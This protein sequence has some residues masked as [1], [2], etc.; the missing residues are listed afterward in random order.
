M[1]SEPL[2]AADRL[3]FHRILRA[4]SPLPDAALAIVDPAARLRRLARGEAFLA[5]GDVATECGVVLAGVMREYYPLADGREV[6][7]S[8]AGPGDGV[9][10]L[11]DLL[12]A[13]PARSSAVAELE[14][15]IAIVPWARLREAAARDASWAQFL[16][17]ITERLYLAKSAREYELLALDAEARYR[18]FRQRFAAIEA[19][20]PLK[21]VASYVG[22]TPEHL[23]RLRKRLART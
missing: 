15:R 3:A 14:T 19:A 23:S 4:V 10:S 6:T 8:F 2:A 13:E 5:A 1:K 7:R 20:I 9:G 12:T 11:S 18:A 21:Q 16:A 17:R 22:I